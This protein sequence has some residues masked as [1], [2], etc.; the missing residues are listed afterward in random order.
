MNPVLYSIHLCIL[1]ASL[2]AC[3]VNR[4]DLHPFYSLFFILLTTT[5][6]VESVS[7]FLLLYTSWST[8][9]IYHLFL[10]MCYS[11]QALI[12]ARALTSEKS[13]RII[14]ISIPAFLIIHILLSVTIQPVTKPNSYAFLLAAASLVA[15]S[16][17]YLHQVMKEPGSVSIQRQPLFWTTTGNLFFFSGAAMLMGLLSYLLDFNKPL[18]SKLFTINYLLNYMLYGLYCIG[19]FCRRKWKMP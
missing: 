18:A 8:Q 13:R 15:M 3:V 17:A 6:I 19:F 2:I 1:L 5:M 4:K 12:Y 11:L 10:P 14:R 16:L 7:F 9:I